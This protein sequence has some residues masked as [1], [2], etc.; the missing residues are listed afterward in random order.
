MDM[1]DPGPTTSGPPD[2][3]VIDRITAQRWARGLAALTGVVELVASF[4]DLPA[5]NRLEGFGVLAVAGAV[6]I[7]ASCTSSERV[8]AAVTGTI[9]AVAVLIVAALPVKGPVPPSAAKPYTSHDIPKKKHHKARP[10][11]KLVEI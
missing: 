5:L 3:P 11:P 4:A 1:M 2:G 7:S 9:A 6:L 8:V 10:K